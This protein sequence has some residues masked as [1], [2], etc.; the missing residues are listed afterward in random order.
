MLD[1]RVWSLEKRYKRGRHPQPP[2]SRG[3]RVERL[4]LQVAVLVLLLLLP[5]S[6]GDDLQGERL[7]IIFLFRA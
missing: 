5:S 7:S 2:P 4:E 1:S 3:V 6:L